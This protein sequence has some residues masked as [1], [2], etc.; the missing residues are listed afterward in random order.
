MEIVDFKKKVWRHYKK[1]KRSFPWRETKDPYKITVSEIM[2]QQTQA[3][4]V[5]AKY[6][7]FLKKWPT[8]KKLA[9]AELQDVLAMWSGLGY[10]RRGKSLWQLAKVVSENHYNK[11]PNTIVAL[12]KLPGIGPYT[13]RAILAFAFNAPHACIETN[14]RS[15]Y[16]YSFF[17]NS[18]RKIADEDLFPLIER[19]LDKK[20]PREWYYALMDYGTFL[21][22]MKLTTNDRHKNYRKQTP[23]KGSLREARGAILRELVIS[24]S[25]LNKLKEKIKLSSDKVE[26]A[27]TA[28]QKEKLVI[29]NGARYSI[30]SK[31]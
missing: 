28:L 19:T 16:I 3:D 25:T 7:A 24:Q 4:R 26:E 22:K 13:A 18:K 12:E 2:L 31:M 11:I 23:F 15:V 29:K 20:N 1:A 30:S 5:V 14:I 21:K 17:P 9:S 27:L 10:N 8:L 6:V